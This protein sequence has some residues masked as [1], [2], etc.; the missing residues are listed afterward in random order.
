MR[1]SPQDPHSFSMLA[2]MASAHLTAGRYAEALSWAEAAVREKPFLLPTMAVAASAA[3]AGR[4]ADAHKAMARLRQLDPTLRLS[5]I[6]T[7]FPMRRDEHIAR[8][9]EGLRQA[10]LPE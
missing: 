8:W 6:R 10:G 1:L 5:N 2:A 4:L 3:L 7:V 9:V